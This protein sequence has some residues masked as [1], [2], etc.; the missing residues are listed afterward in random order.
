MPR[1][2]SEYLEA[3]AATPRKRRAR[4]IPVGRAVAGKDGH[5]TE[6]ESAG[7]QSPERIAGL[8]GLLWPALT[9]FALVFAAGVYALWLLHPGQ[10]QAVSAPPRG[11]VLPSFALVGGW[12]AGLVLLPRVLPRPL[13]WLLL[14]AGTVF[15]A[16]VLS[17]EV[18]AWLQAVLGQ[19]PL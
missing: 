17:R 13:A 8:E 16:I 14:A 19:I 1:L 9:S 4:P 5:S 10:R 15:V 6:E 2:E 18:T 7:E 12:L 3:S 11:V